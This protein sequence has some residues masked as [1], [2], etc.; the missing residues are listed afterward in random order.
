[1]SQTNGIP[2]T[3]ELHLETI[4]S[5]CYSPLCVVL[6]SASANSVLDLLL[7]FSSGEESIFSCLIL[8][9]ISSSKLEL[10]RGEEARL[11]GV[12]DAAP[13]THRSP[14]GGVCTLFPIFFL[15]LIGAEMLG[16]LLLIEDRGR[17]PSSVSL[18]LSLLEL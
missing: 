8:G 7:W 12:D 14:G 13:S 5:L 11:F 4:E 16:L 6:D 17:L 1:M 18:S 9:L 3:K 15:L 2:K 10:V